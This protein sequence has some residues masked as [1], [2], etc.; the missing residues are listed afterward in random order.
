MSSQIEFETRL[1]IQRMVRDA[2]MNTLHRLG[3]HFHLGIEFAYRYYQALKSD[4][5]QLQK[6]IRDVYRSFGL[7]EVLMK[8]IIKQLEARYKK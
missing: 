6:D 7:P 1:I 4:D 5:K 3:G 2:C 8:E